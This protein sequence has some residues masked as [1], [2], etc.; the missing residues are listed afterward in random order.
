[1]DAQ[2]LTEQSRRAEQK[3]NEA[4]RALRAGDATMAAEP[5][6]AAAEALSQAAEALSGSSAPSGEQTGSG[7]TT[8]PPSATVPALPNIEQLGKPWGELPGDVRA[9]LTQELKARYGAEYARAIK[10][11][12]EQLA[13]RKPPPPK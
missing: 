7:V 9:Q 1:V 12:F 10:L 8:L 13:K 6:Q 5:S 2:H 3:M 11:Y 4:G